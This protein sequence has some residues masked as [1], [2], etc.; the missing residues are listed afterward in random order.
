MKLFVL[1][2]ENSRGS[3][4]VLAD[5]LANTLGSAHKVRCGRSVELRDGERYNY[6]INVGCSGSIKHAGAII[7]NDPKAVALCANKL[8]SRELLKKL[9]IS[10]PELWRQ[11]EQIGQQSYPVIGRTTR[12]SRGQ[13]FWF[14]RTPAEAVQAAK[15][16]LGLRKKLITTKKGNR[17]WRDRPAYGEMASHFLQ[18]VN[19]T[20]EFR[21]H[22][23]A[24]KADLENIKPSDYLLVKLSEKLPGPTGTKSTVIKNHDNGWVFSFPKDPGN[25]KLDVV[26]ELGKAAIA[27]LGLHWGAVDIVLC[28]NTGRALVLEVN[29][30]PCLTDDR[31]NTLEKYVKRLKVILG[32]SAPKRQKQ[33][34]VPSKRYSG[35]FQRLGV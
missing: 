34:S 6:I 28:Q 13:G 10:S 29:S 7:L 5:E 22:L 1:S 24:S 21:V 33:S 3:A 19:N 20:R 32:L 27:C 31:S 25:P 30:A 14:C 26:R 16:F 17:V 23:A 9:S 12:H 2:C 11:P 4:A 35:L 18:F 15:G 8:A